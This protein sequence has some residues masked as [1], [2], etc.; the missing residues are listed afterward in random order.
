MNEAYK[1]SDQILA[2][3][4]KW[5]LTSD[6]RIKHGPNEGALYGWKNLNPVSFPFIYSEITGYGITSFLWIYSETGNIHALQAA[7]DASQWIIKNM[8]SYMLLARP[9][10]SDNSDETSDLYYAFDN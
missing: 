10:E 1:N 7:K 6:I 2:Y 3:N 5:L 8:R 4:M 9:S